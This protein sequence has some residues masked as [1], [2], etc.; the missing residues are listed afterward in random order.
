MADNQSCGFL[1]SSKLV[2]ANSQSRYYLL[3]GQ[4]IYIEFENETYTLLKCFVTNPR[5]F[6]TDQAPALD[7][8]RRPD[9]DPYDP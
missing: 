9:M 3:C 2:V 5:Y 6:D 7:I 8:E 1:S 4:T